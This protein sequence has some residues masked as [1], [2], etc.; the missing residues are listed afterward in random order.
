MFMQDLGCHCGECD[1]I[2]YCNDYEDTP[3]CEQE[4]FENITTDE[5]LKAAEVVPGGSKNKMLDAI[6]KLLKG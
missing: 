2:D 3:P 5:F 6:Y 4:R 1:I